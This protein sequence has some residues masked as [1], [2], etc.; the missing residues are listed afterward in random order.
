MTR[1]TDV[2]FLRLLDGSTVAYTENAHRGELVEDS[3]AVEHLQRA[4]DAMRDQALSP[5]ES[6]KF[7]L[8]MLEEVPCDPESST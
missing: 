2:M 8:R 1:R 7:I 5:T 3:G 6:R 4:Y